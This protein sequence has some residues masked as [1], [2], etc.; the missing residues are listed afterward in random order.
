VKIP[1]RKLLFVLIF[2]LFIFFPSQYLCLLIDNK[3]SFLL[4]LLTHCLSF[5]RPLPLDVNVYIINNYL[6]ISQ[7][8]NNTDNNNENIVFFLPLF[9]LISELSEKVFSIIPSGIIILVFF[10]FFFFF[11]FFSFL[12]FF[13]FQHSLSIYTLRKKEGNFRENEIIII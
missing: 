10:F 5:V 12:L 13:L 9:T 7:D 1:V 11:F 6:I 8:T 2:S 3:T 4:F